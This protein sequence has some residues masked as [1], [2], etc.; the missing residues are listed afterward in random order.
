MGN[1]I[2]VLMVYFMTSIYDSHSQVLSFLFALLF[3]YFDGTLYVLINH[4][5]YKSLSGHRKVQDIVDN[6]PAPGLGQHTKLRYV[7]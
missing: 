1:K 3:P 5:G 4:H 6:S 7:R 2:S